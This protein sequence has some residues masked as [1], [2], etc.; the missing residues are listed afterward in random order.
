MVDAVDEGTVVGTTPPTGGYGTGAA[1]GEYLAAVT[2][3]NDMRLMPMVDPTE[4]DFDGVVVRF[5]PLDNL[6]HS[7]VPSCHLTRPVER[8]KD[9]IA[10]IVTNQSPYTYGL[11][12]STFGEIV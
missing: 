7:L 2:L 3:K 12:R 1:K 6:G 10:P 9:D 11:P 4:G 8:V 5:G